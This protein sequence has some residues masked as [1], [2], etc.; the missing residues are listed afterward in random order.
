MESPF[1]SEA[2]AF[3]FLLITIGAFALIVVASL[4]EPWLGFAVFLLLVVAAVV[5]YLR[6][7]SPGTARP[8][9]RARRRPG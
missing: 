8:A 3:R 1:R 4:I 7:R 2:A 9:R 6:E 5:V